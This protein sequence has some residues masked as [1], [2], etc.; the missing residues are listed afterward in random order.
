MAAYA[1]Q[2]AQTQL[3]QVQVPQGCVAG[4]MLQIQA[5]SGQVLQVQIPQGMVPGSVFHV[6]VPS[7]Q[8]VQAV[9][10]GQIK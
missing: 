9:Q 1:Q 7:A 6:Q 10:L 4:Q 5:P 3:M 8:P 2:Q